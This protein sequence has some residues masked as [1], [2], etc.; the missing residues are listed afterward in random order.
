MRSADLEEIRSLPLFRDMAPAHFAELTRGAY[1]QSFPPQ[2]DLIVEGRPAD[3]LHVITDGAVELF[4][5]WNGRETTMSVVR[6]VSTFILA[7][8]IN[9]AP[10]LMSA[11]TLVPSRVA[12]IPGT[13][14]R[15][16]FARDP[17]FAQAIV[18]EL[19]GSY[20]GVVRHAKN[21]KL[22]N[23]KER[24]AA[25]LI[26]ECER[27]GRSRTFALPYE[28]RIIASYLGMTPE[29]LSRALKQLREDGV[30]IDGS[31]VDL[32]DFDRLCAIA[33]PGRLMDR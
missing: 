17:A 30:T 31:T 3:F 10:Y 19:A 23:S 11:R 25:F 8:C 13:D 26:A 12:L 7:A 24:L 33:L 21:I 32:A 27:N 5:R 22:R 16:V 29:N 4:A 2:V 14:L 9:D 20:R 1:H 6:P 15:S 18:R 28:K